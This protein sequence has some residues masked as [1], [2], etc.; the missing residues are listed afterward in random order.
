MR[1]EHLALRRYGHFTDFELDFGQGPSQL[2]EQTIEH[3]PGQSPG[4][5]EGKPGSQGS[6]IQKAPLADLHVLYGPN[7]AGKSTTLAAINDLLYGFGR[8]TPWAF[9]HGYELLE[10]EATLSQQGQRFGVRRFK[11]HLSNLNNDR[12]ERFPLDLQGLSR[13]EYARRFSFDEQSLRD[14]GEQILQ[15]SGDVG[16]A[17]FSASAGLNNLQTAIHSAMESANAF[18]TPSKKNTELKALKD[19]LQTNKKLLTDSKLDTATY[20][21]LQ[22]NLSS[23]QKRKDLLATDRDKLQKKL[24]QLG[25]RRTE[26]NLAQQLSIL[27]EKR[28]ALAES[29][30]A[31]ALL[32][33]GLDLTTEESSRTEIEKTRNLINRVSTA[34]SHLSELEQ[35]QAKNLEQLAANTATEHETQI[36]ENREHI[37]R[38]ISRN[39]AAKEWEVQLNESRAALSSSQ[40]L[41]ESTLLQMNLKTDTALEQTLPGPEQL[42]V[43][44]AL[45]NERVQ[46][47]AKFSHAQ[48][49]LAQ[50]ESKQPAV[51]SATI[52]STVELDIA[53]D[54]LNRIKQDAIPQQYIAADDALR[55]S[56]QSHQLLADELGF[57]DSFISTLSLPEESWLDIQLSTLL[58]LRSDVEHLAQQIRTEREEQLQKQ[59]Q[60]AE[61]VLSGVVDSGSLARDKAE[62]D[63]AWKEHFTQITAAPEGSSTT[64]TAQAFEVAMHQHDSHVE[65]AL[66]DTEKGAQLDLLNNQLARQ[67]ASLSAKE[68]QSDSLNISVT[69][70]ETTILQRVSGFYPQTQIDPSELRHRFLQTNKLLHLQADVTSASLQLEQLTALSK[71]EAN[72]LL[73]TLSTLV[74]E[75]TF[76][77]LGKLQLPDMIIQADK[78]IKECTEAAE[79]SRK[80]IDSIEN[81]RK[82]HKRRSLEA[83][84]AQSQLNS[85]QHQWLEHTKDSVLADISIPQASDTLQFCRDLNIALH[86]RQVA[87]SKQ[88]TL[89]QRIEL[90]NSAV[91]SLLDSFSVARLSDINNLLD[92]ANQRSSALSQLKQ[93]QVQ[94]DQTISSKKDSF[95]NDQR[96]LNSLSAVYNVESIDELISML[97]RTMQHRSMQQQCADALDSLSELTGS[98][99]TEL[100]INN[101]KSEDSIA[102]LE[103][104]IQTSKTALKDAS[105]SYDEANREW[106]LAMQSLQ[107]IGDGHDHARLSQERAN[108]LLEIEDKAKS[109]VQARCGQMALRA[110]ISKFRQEHQSV[111]L[112]EAKAAF[113]T[114]TAGKYINLVPRDDGRGN[115]QLFAIDENQK[116]RSVRELSTG[117]H[118]QLYLALRAAAHADYARQRPP[119]PFVADDIMESFDDERSAAAFKVLNDMAKRG[120]V[121]YLTH[122]KHLLDI[123]R[124]SLGKDGVQIHYF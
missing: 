92:T 80:I 19:A 57:S 98:R 75:N 122:H 23:A 63:L 8:T 18:W 104:D 118:Y 49:E 84:N 71:A 21:K 69:D 82:E 114:L 36:L 35:Q 111:L 16:Q 22:K 37:I 39:S 30:V 89:E 59:Q 53:G 38:L 11:N 95:T 33:G 120:Q 124:D 79:K 15:S 105:T 68:A 112:T 65:T 40:Q 12:L 81:Y 93:Q 85:W 28:N 91:K 10:I 14:G 100:D 45:L 72:N 107:D 113:T 58:S 29:G 110:A 52:T 115:E 117:A 78:I 106:A 27:F 3:P 97:S 76:K 116:P 44:E 64:R 26:Q 42:S 47:Q 119:L 67:E 31:Q 17:L 101:F 83:N 87:T 94:I 108:L 70:S 74:A 6:N 1:L 60:C 73:Q 99:I 62:R 61:L 34:K 32:A 50:L 54:V 102:A 51:E 9:L 55:N 5:T 20:K 66:R 103:S 25:T 24:D 123:A 56:R 4:H 48:D 88:N 43:L 77:A 96:S 46:Q 13:E 121:I 109:T 86:S 41:I 2:T 7:E 90:H